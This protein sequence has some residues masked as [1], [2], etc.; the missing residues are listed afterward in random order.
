MLG[1]VYLLLGCIPPLAAGPLAG[2]AFINILKGGKGWYRVPFWM[3]LV[4]VN[5]LVMFWVASS[6]DAWLSISSFSA[7]FFYPGG[8][9]RHGAGDA[10]YL[11]QARSR[12]ENRGSAQGLV[13]HRPG[14]DP[15]SAD[16]FVRGAITLRTTVM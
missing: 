15:C 6:T 10:D 3:V 5:G 12:W 14:A 11:A 16:R 1:I 13:P 9:H 7:C 8:C 2:L 4:L